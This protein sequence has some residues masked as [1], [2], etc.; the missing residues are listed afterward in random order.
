[1]KKLIYTGYYVD[2]K[3]VRHQP[4]KSLWDKGG[5]F[6]I[7]V[8]TSIGVFIDRVVR[9]IRNTDFGK[10]FSENYLFTCDKPTVLDSSYPIHLRSFFE[11][12]DGPHWWH[13]DSEIIPYRDAPMP[14][15]DKR[16]LIEECKKLCAHKR[17]GG[18][19]V[20]STHANTIFDLPFV[21]VDPDLYPCLTQLMSDIGLK[22][23]MSL[24]LASLNPG[25]YLDVH[26]DDQGYNRPEAIKY[27]KG[28]NNFYW[29]LTDPKDTYFKYGR[30]GLLPIERPL[31]INTVYH[32]HSVVN[33]SKTTTRTILNLVGRYND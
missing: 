29:Q 27:L 30:C 26:N 11:T 16:L 22:E 8:H 9:C 13:K 25:Q 20:I 23:L 12:A 10:D 19:N 4:A 31:F 2:G 17:D 18:Y 7:W 28:C 33:V 32:V 6:K 21:K 14:K 24:G 5:V 3:G 1:M 15:V